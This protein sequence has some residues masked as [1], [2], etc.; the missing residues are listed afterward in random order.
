MHRQQFC[1]K[2]ICKFWNLLCVF[3]SVFGLFCQ[4]TWHWKRAKAAFQECAFFESSKAVLH[5][6]SGASQG[7]G[8]VSQRSFNY[9]RHT[10][11]REKGLDF[12]SRFVQ[13]GQTKSLCC[14]WQQARLSKVSKW[15]H[16]CA[17]Q[18]QST[19][20]MWD[21][22]RDLTMLDW[23]YM[24]WLCVMVELRLQPGHWQI[25]SST[26]W[27]H[28]KSA[29]GGVALDFGPMMDVTALPAGQAAAVVQQSVKSSVIATEK[30]WT[31]WG[32]E[33][34]TSWILH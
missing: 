27:S 4:P 21:L 3:L 14:R 23:T 1:D 5:L 22:R 6:M 32:S 8:C 25:F 16:N 31:F 33:S 30:K 24:L 26:E 28:W 34:S 20:E 11:E 29:G 9:V 18:P 12:R 2:F 17:P 19:V 13:W 7:H 10:K 15:L